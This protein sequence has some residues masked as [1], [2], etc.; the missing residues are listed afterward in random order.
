M[1]YKVIYEDFKTDII[2]GFVT[3]VEPDHYLI[4]INTRLSEADQDKALKHELYHIEHNHFEV[5]AGSEKSVDQIE[6]ETR[7]A[8]GEA[9]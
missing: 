6:C 7:E 4:G 1:N 9:F 5:I 2:R 3:E 8:I